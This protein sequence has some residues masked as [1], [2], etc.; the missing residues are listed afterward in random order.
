VRVTLLSRASSR[1]V[2]TLITA[3]VRVALGRNAGATL[4]SRASS[5][6][7]VALVTA[8][9]VVVPNNLI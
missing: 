3:A 5:R 4:L 6:L 1:L 2:V 9:F 7:V 8:A